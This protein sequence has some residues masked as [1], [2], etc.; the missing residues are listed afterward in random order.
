[1]IKEVPDPTFECEGCVYEVSLSV[2]NMHVVLTQ[3]IQLNT[4][5]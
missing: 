1:M 3:T 2:C 4:L 5:R